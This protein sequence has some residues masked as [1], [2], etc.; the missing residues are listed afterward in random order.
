M[1]TPAYDQFFRRY[2]DTF[3]QALDGTGEPDAVRAF[4]AEAFVGA[5]AG[6]KVSSGQNDDGYGQVL[7]Q[8]MD[9]Y[10]RIG[11]RRMQVQQVTPSRIDDGHDLVRV[12]FMADY[13]VEGRAPFSIAFELSYLLQRRADGPKIFCFISGDET[14]VYRAHGLVD[15][16]SRPLVKAAA[17]SG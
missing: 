1:Q 11:T 8:G 12:Q 5:S 15:A 10:R 7:R 16:Q 3:N 14:A 6:G 4:Y 9:F 2:V 13:H 17:R